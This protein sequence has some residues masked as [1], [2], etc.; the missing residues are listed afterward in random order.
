MDDIAHRTRRRKSAAAAARPG[1]TAVHPPF[2]VTVDIV[3]FRVIDVTL[4]VL[5]VRRGHAPYA[6][7]WALPGG[8]KDPGEALDA[9]ARRE[10]AEETHVRSIAALAQFKSYGDP[11]RDPR[12]DV[13][14][15]AYLGVASQRTMPKSG[16]DAAAAAFHPL[17]DVLTGT[18]SLAFDHRQIVTDAVE[19]LRRTIETT[20]LATR[21]VRSP[22]T[23][24]ELRR[25]Y[26]AIWDVRLDAAKFRRRLLSARGWLE[27]TGRVAAGDTRR[28]KP[29]QRYRRGRRSRLGGCLW[30]ERFRLERIRA[31][32]HASTRL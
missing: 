15:V 27:P 26:E 20:N 30:A 1:E 18:L 22:F 16:D 12:M 29:V 3:V 11:G 7:R 6:G 28:G 8:F 2:A 31:G 14:T 19:Q 5:L 9:A 10:L 17:R 13:V 21:F 25:V 23:L 4:E 32:R 24:G